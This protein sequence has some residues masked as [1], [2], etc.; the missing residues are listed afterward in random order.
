MSF[1]V[2][3]KKS[4]DCCDSLIL[5][6]S[7]QPQATAFGPAS[8]CLREVR[9]I[10][11]TRLNLPGGKFQGFGYGRLAIRDVNRTADSCGEE[12]FTRRGDGKVFVLP[13]H[14]LRLRFAPRQ[15]FTDAIEKHFVG[16][17][18]DGLVGPLDHEQRRLRFHREGQAERDAAAGDLVHEFR[19]R[20]TEFLFEVLH[21]LEEAAH[22]RRFEIF[23]CER[24][25]LEAAVGVDLREA[26]D[27]LAGVLDLENESGLGW[28]AFE[29]VGN[30][31]LHESTDCEDEQRNRE[32]DHNGNPRQSDLQM[33]LPGGPGSFSIS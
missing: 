17:R 2:L 28:D 7:S 31:G 32:A 8:L 1:F 29:R 4:F 16:L 9:I 19:P 27:E 18:Y 20:G 13:R 15:F 5:A 6:K 24:E 26:L 30:F 10:G 22:L 14:H 25:L 33:V 12:I 11:D 21:R 3:A 23:L